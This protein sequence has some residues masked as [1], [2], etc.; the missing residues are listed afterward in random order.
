VAKA[1]ELLRSAGSKIP[2]NLKKD[3]Y[4][5][6]AFMQ[7]ALMDRYIQ[8]EVKRGYEEIQPEARKLL[9]VVATSASPSDVASSAA[10]ARA[11][12]EQPIVTPEMKAVMDEA[13]KLGEESNAAIGYREP[14]PFIA[15]KLDLSETGWWAKTLIDAMATTDTEKI[16][17]AARMITHYSDPGEGGIYD[18]LGWPN[19]SR[20]L[21][22]GEALWG[23]MPFPGPAR[24]SQYN[25][26]Y[27]MGE[28]EGVSLV[29]DGLDPAAQY[30]VRVSVGAH[31]EGDEA[32]ALKGMTLS[33]GMEADGQVISDGF[34]IPMN[35]ITFH[36]F[37]L[38]QSL[39]ADGKVQISMTPK[40]PIFM[41][42]G[43]NEIWLMKKDKM[44]WTAR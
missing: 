13:I 28:K 19:E 36:E 9:E 3:D 1:V 42:T 14:A 31:V 4:R 39:T 17:N 24:H 37:D 26:A 7:K 16:K 6:R 18:D 38:P 10:Q 21:T 27:T 29:F 5:W 15:P 12:L 2:D 22:R 35:E 33:E 25:L 32:S 43:V 8:L 44:P 34:S 40:M 30:V 20:Y 11:L 41:I 23:F